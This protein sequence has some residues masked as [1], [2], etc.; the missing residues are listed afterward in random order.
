MTLLTVSE[1]SK[2]GG[3]KEIVDWRFLLSLS[4]VA[5]RFIYPHLLM[6]FKI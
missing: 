1:I 3:C 5:Q 6:V 4:Q 2:F